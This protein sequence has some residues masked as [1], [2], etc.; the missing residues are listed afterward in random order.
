MVD[1]LGDTDGDRATQVLCHGDFT[2]SQV[3][4]ADHAV[5]GVVDFDTVC[6]S[7]SAI[8]LGRFLAQMELL[9]YQGIRPVS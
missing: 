8:D 2:P 1:R 5:C 3:L 7:D 4:L 6:W 9:V